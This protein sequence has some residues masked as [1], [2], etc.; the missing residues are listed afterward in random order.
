V[1]EIPQRLPDEIAYLSDYLR[2][3]YIDPD[4]IVILYFDN[5]M[6]VYTPEH[7]VD[8]STPDPT[9]AHTI[10]YRWPDGQYVPDKLPDKD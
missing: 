2:N 3:F 8:G 9:Y 10:A 6:A 1:S 7:Y 4:G 5:G